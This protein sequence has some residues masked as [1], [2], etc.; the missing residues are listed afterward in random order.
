MLG[1]REAVSTDL[2]AA[3]MQ[4]YRNELKRQ[5]EG[6]V[7]ATNFVSTPVREPKGGLLKRKTKFDRAE[8]YRKRHAA[9]VGSQLLVS[10]L[11]TKLE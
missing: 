10:H 9:G 11:R 6:K 8:I 2:V 1:E 7:T 5:C 3:Q 4:R